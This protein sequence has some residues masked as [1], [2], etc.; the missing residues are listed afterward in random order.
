MAIL[1]PEG[2]FSHSE[3]AVAQQ[4]GFIPTTLGPRILRAETAA[5][6]AGSILQYRFGDMKQDVP[7]QNRIAN[8]L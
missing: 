1:G 7:N 3:I 2:G 4:A 6:A 8:Q 5:I